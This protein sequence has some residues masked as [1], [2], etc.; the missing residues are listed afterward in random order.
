MNTGIKINLEEKRRKRI[1]LEKDRI[2]VSQSVIKDP[3]RRKNTQPSVVTTISGVNPSVNPTLSTNRTIPPTN[4]SSKSSRSNGTSSNKSK[5]LRDSAADKEKLKFVNERRNS[6]RLPTPKQ[7]FMSIIETDTMKNTNNAQNINQIINAIKNE[8]KIKSDK[9]DRNENKNESIN[10]KKKNNDSQKDYEKT[11]DNNENSEK[12][13]S[14]DARLK[15]KN[16][17]NVMKIIPNPRERSQQ[18]QR[19]TSK[20][21]ML[22]EVKSAITNATNIDLNMYDVH[23]SDFDEFDSLSDYGNSLNGKS[24]NTSADC[25]GTSVASKK[26][27][28]C[29]MGVMSA[30]S[31]YR[32]I[33]VY[34]QCTHKCIHSYPLNMYLFTHMTCYLS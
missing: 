1:L 34:M 18:Q 28:T 11:N 16:D 17:N 12:Y 9:E 31:P 24:V 25:R 5:N 29:M 23:D 26:V 30:F 13:E 33:Y 32:R 3:Y 21:S 19:S 8:F 2:N 7:S 20:Y 4:Q 14:L 22:S 27:D 15:R 6:R 10:E